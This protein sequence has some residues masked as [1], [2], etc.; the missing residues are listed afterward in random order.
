MGILAIKTILLESKSGPTL[1]SKILRSSV[2][3]FV[4]LVCMTFGD[5]EFWSSV[6][7]F[8]GEQTGSAGPVPGGLS[9]GVHDQDLRVI[10]L[11]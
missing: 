8:E 10:G 11:P 2:S 1:N 7:A 3:D 4:I 9:P 5:S 6:P